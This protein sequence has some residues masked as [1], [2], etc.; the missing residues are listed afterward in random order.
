M[1]SQQRQDQIRDLVNQ[2]EQLVGYSIQV[3]DWAVSEMA[4]TLEVANL[5]DVGQYMGRHQRDAS[6][7]P[8]A[9]FVPEWYGMMPWAKFGMSSAEYNRKLSEYDSGFRAL[10]GQMAPQDL[11]ERALHEHQGAMTMGQ[12]ETWLMTQ[13]AIKNQYGWLKYG[14]DFQQFQ[15]QKLQMRAGF[16]RELTDAEATAQLQYHHAA[17]GGNVGVTAQQTLG[18]VEKK[19]AQTGVGGSVVR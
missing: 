18:Q 17:Q 6:Q 11:V 4:G 3:P 2:W 13:D 8:G 7:D 5:F 19:Q 12:F 15:T 1:A 10:T 14:L 16:G 9:L